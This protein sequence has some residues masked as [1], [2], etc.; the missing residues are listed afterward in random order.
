MVFLELIPKLAES[1]S[2]KNIFILFLLS[3]LLQAQSQYPK[4]YFQSPLGIPLQLSGNFGELR[5][6]HFHAGLDMKTAQRVGLPIYAA[7]DGYISRIKI[8]TFGNGKTLYITHPNGYTTVYAHLL[9]MEGDIE[10]FVKKKHYEE[11][12]FELE[13]FLKPNEMPITKGQV[14]AYSGN[15]GASQGPHLHFEIR[16]TKTE[17]II[18]PLFFGFDAL[19]KDT[20]KPQV[21]SVF[22]YPIGN[23]SVVNQSQRPIPL[24]LTLQKDGTYL[25]DPVAARGKI[26]FGFIGTDKDNISNN[27]NGIFSA[28]GFYNGTLTYSFQFNTYAF[29]EMKYINVLIDYERYKKTQQ[30][31]QQLFRLN[32]F[33]FNCIS[34]D[35]N[36]G[37]ISLSPNLSGSYRI[38]VADFYGNVTTITI[39]V[40][41]DSNAIVIPKEP[42]PSLY[43]VNFKKDN[44]YEKENWLINFPA[45]TFFNDF[46]MN[47][48]VSNKVLS[49]HEDVVPVQSPFIVQ[50]QDL[51]H[52]IAKRDK[53]FIG[54]VKGKKVEYYPTNV[55]E[56]SFSIK[57]KTLGKYGLIIDDVKPVIVM[58]KSIQ[59]KWL[60]DQKEVS[61]IIFDALSGIKSYNGYLNDQWILMEYDN[62][63][64]T[65]THSFDD[66]I[67]AEGANTLKVIVEDQLGNS[68]TFETRF[69]RSQ[70]PK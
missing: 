34:T 66:G 14:I 21:T 56:G 45:N 57:T 40:V 47:L 44:I 59:G 26:G 25:A 10:T 54:R 5:P 3:G 50:V 49:L 70:K 23:E 51:S 11:K 4:D 31:V 55:S 39:P 19:I 35:A 63:T 38:E 24:A 30:R 46:D 48:S 43:A 67:V 69:F 33:D 12:S 27:N 29:D 20:R 18:N 7:A 68:S 17:W 64:N 6:N 42:N 65:L 13:V 16:D 32:P 36:N 58:R 1:K 53:M 61:V 8:S 41:Y 60:T 15:T 28:K 62:K 52:S 9:K 22:A 37:V 2:M